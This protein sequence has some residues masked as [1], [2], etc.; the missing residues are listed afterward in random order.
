LAASEELPQSIAEHVLQTGNPIVL[1][2]AANEG[3]FGADPYVRKHGLKSVLAVPLRRTARSSG[4][5][6]LENNLA[7]LAFTPE[8]V[9]WL[10]LLSGQIGTALDN[11]EL[12]H[13]L[14]DKADQARFL[15]DVSA[16]L[17]ESLDYDTTV[18]QAVRL[19]VPGL[20]DM[21]LLDLVEG[22]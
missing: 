21:C 9:Q 18:N 5:L 17:A 15:A 6:Y 11:A 13:Q 4:V 19:V 14:E 2:D 1:G 8:R 16:A 3:G 20:A 7:T 12:V 22:K 10:E